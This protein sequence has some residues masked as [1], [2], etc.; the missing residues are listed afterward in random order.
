MDTPEV[1]VDATSEKARMSR[2]SEWAYRAA[3]ISAKQDALY[4]ASLER[5]CFRIELRDAFL[6]P[7][8]VTH[9]GRLQLSSSTLTPRQALEFARWVV[10][11]FEDAS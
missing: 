10:E 8:E 4:H 7:A 11:T 2:A 3:D 9:Q 6:I 1:L 5:P